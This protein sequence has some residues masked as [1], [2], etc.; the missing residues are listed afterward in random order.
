MKKQLSI[1]A[2]AFLLSVGCMSFTTL[3]DDGCAHADGSRLQGKW[4]IVQSKFP[5]PDE[6][7]DDW[8]DSPTYLAFRQDG[9]FSS[10][11]F[12]GTSCG[13]YKVKGKQIIVEREGDADL[14]FYV[15]SVKDGV[16][17]VFCDADDPYEDRYLRVALV[18]ETPE[19]AREMLLGHWRHETASFESDESFEDFNAD[20]N[21]YYFGK[22]K[23]DPLEAGN[24]PDYAGRYVGFLEYEGYALSFDK[25]DCTHGYVYTMDGEEHEIVDLNAYSMLYDNRGRFYRYPKR[26]DYAVV[27]VRAYG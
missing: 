10:Q 6:E 26:I 17:D 22:I 11:G 9:S 2:L 27:E 7:L 24:Y 19:Q 14:R 8:V 23:S 3:T 18:P 5:A 4:T 21:I 1:T 20:G 12:Y 13:T 15:L 16:A 25:D